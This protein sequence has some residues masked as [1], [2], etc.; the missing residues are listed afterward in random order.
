MV[1]EIGCFRN[2]RSV[3]VGGSLK[4]LVENNKSGWGIQRW[5]FEEQ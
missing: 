5:W 4:G 2:N 1:S 3:E